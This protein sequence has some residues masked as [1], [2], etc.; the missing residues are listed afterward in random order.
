[1]INITFQSSFIQA[2]FLAWD[3]CSRKLLLGSYLALLNLLAALKAAF[4]GALGI[5]RQDASSSLL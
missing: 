2:A 3:I 5:L 1:M 4:D